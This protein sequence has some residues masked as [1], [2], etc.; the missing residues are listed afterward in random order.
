MC[1]ENGLPMLNAYR[2][3][4]CLVLAQEESHSV[5]SLASHVRTHV[6]DE[7]KQEQLFPSKSVQ[8]SRITESFCYDCEMRI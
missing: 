5:I 1:A 4:S 7:Y 6:C 2:G 3:S 8:V